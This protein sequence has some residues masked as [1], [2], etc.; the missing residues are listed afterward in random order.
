MYEPLTSGEYLY[1]YSFK[2]YKGE[3]DLLVEMVE[4]SGEIIF[5]AS[6]VDENN[7]ATL[8]YNFNYQPVYGQRYY[9]KFEIKTG[10]A[11]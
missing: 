6:D 8:T 5:N 7:N 9:V 10:N 4:D 2:L 1:S 11:Y 3:P